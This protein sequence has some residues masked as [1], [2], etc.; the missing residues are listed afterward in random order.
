M[1][2]LHFVVGWICDCELTVCVSHKTSEE[3]ALDSAPWNQP[4]VLLSGDQIEICAG[5]RG[6][7]NSRIL[8]LHTVMAALV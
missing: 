7:S 5:G 6:S 4:V 8:A 2:D 1:C 3:R